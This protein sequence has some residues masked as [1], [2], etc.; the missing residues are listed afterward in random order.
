MD[1]NFGT[2]A[3]FAFVGT[4]SNVTIRGL[5]I[6]EYRTASQLAAIDA[7]SGSGWLIE[8]NLVTW[9]HSGGIRIGP[10]GR[11][12]NNVI[13]YNGQLG[14]KAC[15]SNGL[16][17][18][19]EIAYNNSFCPAGFPVQQSGGGQGCNQYG[20]EGGGSKF[21]VTSG[22]RVIGNHVHGN[23]GPGLW[24]DIQNDEVLY[25]GNLVENNSSGGIFHEISYDARIVGNTARGNTLTQTIPHPAGG[26]SRTC[27]G[28]GGAYGHAEIVIANSRGIDRDLEITGNTVGAK[29]ILVV[30]QLR[31]GGVYPTRRIYPHD[32]AGVSCTKVGVDTEGSFN[33]AQWDAFLAG[34]PK[35]GARC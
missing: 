9:N 15:G 23:C 1:G 29:G 7:C 33:Q 18:G 2:I 17:Q 4:A 19:N 35:L 26:A 13:T 20:F 28:G 27:S 5:E 25:E 21:A 6:R 34:N 14:V 11:A 12:I 31:N 3:V 16:Y 30:E 8:N 32:N 10:N 22:L 24:T